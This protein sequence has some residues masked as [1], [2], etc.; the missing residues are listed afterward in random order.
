MGLLITD[1]Y[2][3]SWTIIPG[4]SFLNYEIPI[5]FIAKYLIIQKF[6]LKEGYESFNK[7]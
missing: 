4:V 1:L 2:N 5:L 6:Y 3:T 7:L